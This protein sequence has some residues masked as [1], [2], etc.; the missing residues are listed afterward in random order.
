MFSVFNGLLKQLH[1]LI[2]GLYV[3][4]YDIVFSQVNTDFK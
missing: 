4:M 1:K 2:S 3:Y